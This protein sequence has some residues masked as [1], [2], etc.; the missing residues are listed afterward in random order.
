[1]IIDEE[2]IDLDRGSR[3]GEGWGAGAHRELGSKY[4]ICREKKVANERLFLFTLIEKE[5]MSMYAVLLH[6]IWLCSCTLTLD[7]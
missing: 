3:L 4:M 1:M 6:G 5:C 7:S 2:R